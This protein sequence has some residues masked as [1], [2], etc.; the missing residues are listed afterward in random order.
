MEEIEIIDQDVS[1]YGN[2][3][4][5]PKQIVLNHIIKIRIEKN[6]SS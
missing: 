2:K 1:K 3:D 6:A 5:S 4:L